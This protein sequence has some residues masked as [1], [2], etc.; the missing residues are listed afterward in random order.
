MDLRRSTPRA[1][2][3]G[4]RRRLSAYVR[5]R[6][7][8][9]TQHTHEHSS[10]SMADDDHKLLDQISARSGACVQRSRVP[11]RLALGFRSQR[12]SWPGGGL[13]GFFSAERPRFASLRRR[14]RLTGSR[15]LPARSGQDVRQGPVPVHVLVGLLHD[16][17]ARPVHQ[18]PRS[19]PLRWADHPRGCLLHLFVLHAHQDVPRFGE[20]EEA[21]VRLPSSPPHP[22]RSFVTCTLNQAAARRHGCRLHDDM[23]TTARSKSS[24]T[25]VSHDDAAINTTAVN[26]ALA[27]N[28]LCVLSLSRGLCR[29]RLLAAC[30]RG[31]FQTH[32]SVLCGAA[33]T[34]STYS[35]WCSSA[36]TSC[37]RSRSRPITCYR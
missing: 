28:N 30:R 3:G 4:D 25:H 11:P 21:R 18:H 15:R 33:A 7:P 10:S 12:E 5:G 37:A 36:S 34:V 8:Y 9:S 31:L 26:Y 2:I 27:F 35:S 14:R 1:L 20:G 24:K 16:P 17:A 29:Y 19:E 32:R 23:R 6:W 13:C 22:P